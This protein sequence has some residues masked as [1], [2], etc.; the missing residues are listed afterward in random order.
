M[1]KL[2]EKNVF[3]GILTAVLLT[4]VNKAGTS[5]VLVPFIVTNIIYVVINYRYLPETSQKT[6]HEVSENFSKE[7]PGKE[8]LANLRRTFYMLW[9]D[10]RSFPHSSSILLQILVLIIQVI[11]VLLTFRVGLQAYWALANYF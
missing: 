7:L 3:G 10:H 2:P 5:L 6:A 1:I 4:A 11:C 9:K 8:L